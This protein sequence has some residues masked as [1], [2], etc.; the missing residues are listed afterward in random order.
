[1]LSLSRVNHHVRNLASGYYSVTASVFRIA[2]NLV[3]I[4]LCGR[5]LKRYFEEIK[6]RQVFRLSFPENMMES[7]F[8][9]LPRK[10]FRPS[11]FFP[12]PGL[13]YATIG[14]ARAGFKNQ[15]AFFTDIHFK[16][17]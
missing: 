13:T 4:L 8:I 15:I 14:K 1:M 7:N 2:G 17:S 11:Y 3:I 9:F 16:N 12:Q 6:G 10:S 5:R